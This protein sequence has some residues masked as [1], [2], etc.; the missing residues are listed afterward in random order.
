MVGVSGMTIR[1]IIAELEQ[2]QGPSREL[3]V[4]I[5]DLA[6]KPATWGGSKIESWFPCDDGTVGYN[7][8]DGYRHLG[9][10]AIPRYTSSIDAAK[11]LVPQHCA[12]ELK[13]RITGECDATVYG[14]DT[15]AS[16]DGAT[17]PLA[18]CIAALK[19]TTQ[20]GEE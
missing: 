16:G 14:Q 9:C 11:T 1:D 12:I 5:F 20:A 18:L 6:G 2:A 7:T 3:D 10:E 8:A 13:E 15:F 19:A 4:K 17:L